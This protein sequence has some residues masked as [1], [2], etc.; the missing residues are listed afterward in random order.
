MMFIA[1]ARI[2]SPLEVK[3]LFFFVSEFFVSIPLGSD[4]P[5]APKQV[6]AAP[7]FNWMDRIL[8]VV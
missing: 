5:I 8:V 2:H 1:V 6:V 3:C 4:F 7:I